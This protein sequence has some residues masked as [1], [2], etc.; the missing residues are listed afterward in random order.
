M[1]RP[2]GGEESLPIECVRLRPPSSSV[3]SVCGS[4][5]LETRR[6]LG[7]GLRPM[8]RRKHSWASRSPAERNTQSLRFAWARGASIARVE[9]G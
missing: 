4:Q 5:S 8:H 9:G 1:K 3:N 6:R 2:R 7:L